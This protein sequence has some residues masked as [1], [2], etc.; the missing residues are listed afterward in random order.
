[1]ANRI[2]VVTAFVPL[3]VKHMSDVDYHWLGQQMLGAAPCPHRFFDHYP[4]EKCWLFNELSDLGGPEIWSTPATE[5]PS[6]R[7]ATPE[8]HVLSN[9]V[10]HTRTQW[11]M[12][13]MAEDP[14]LDVIIWLDL[15]ILKQ[16]K[17]NGNPVAQDDIASFC[18]RVA[19]YPF[20]DIPFPGIEPMKPVLPHGNNWRFCGSTHVWPTKWL[21]HIHA[22]Y[23][24]SLRKFI[25]T[26]NCVPLDL[27][28]WPAVEQCSW[29]PFHWYKAEYDA[30]Q[31]RNFP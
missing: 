29:L 12:E 24:F 22:A 25:R 31:L 26:Y 17:W 6:D 7:Y 21:P 30:S 13:A 11:A 19:E 5:T 3:N 18:R 15:G 8:D 23:K 27:A 1:M 14:K 9:I 2:K 28:I 4:I 10:Q 16:G 20:N